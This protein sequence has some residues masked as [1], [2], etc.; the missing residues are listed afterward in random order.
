MTISGVE[1][2]EKSVRLIGGKLT[3]ESGSAAAM[4]VLVDGIPRAEVNMDAAE[5]GYKVRIV[6][7]LIASCALREL[8]VLRSDT[9]DHKV[10]LLNDLF[11]LKA[12]SI[13]R[14]RYECGDDWV[15]E[16]GAV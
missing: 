10:M 5:G 6:S 2:P 14:I 11:A 13:D 1:V 8:G 16:F 12:V 15:G 3:D 4:L 7:M 9:T